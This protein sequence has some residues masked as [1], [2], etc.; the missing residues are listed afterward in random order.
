MGNFGNVIRTNV[1]TNNNENIGQFTSC[2]IK[3]TIQLYARMNCA[4]RKLQMLDEDQNTNEKIRIKVTFLP[5]FI[6]EA[7]NHHNRTFFSTRP[8]QGLDIDH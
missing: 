5:E 1:Q 8:P 4:R 3:E 6:N 2:S 7:R